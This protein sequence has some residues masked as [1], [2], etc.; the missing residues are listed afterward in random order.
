[1]S[2]TASWGRGWALVTGASEGLGEDMARVLAARGFPLVLTARRAERLEALARE[3]RE[4]HEV[5]VHV[6]PADLSS[7]GAA[8]AIHERIEDA[9]L[10]VWW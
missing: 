5:E 7:P 4:A 8:Q 9:R 3:L 10:P 2:E 1:M 6:V